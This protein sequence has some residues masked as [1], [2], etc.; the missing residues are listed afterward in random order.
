MTK[1]KVDKNEKY[2]VQ[3]PREKSQLEIKAQ[4]RE[5]EAK[6]REAKVLPKETKISFDSWYH[7]RAARFAKCHLKEIIWADFKS[8]KLNKE[9]KAEVYDKAL[10]RYG[11]KLD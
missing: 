10:E 6:K 9:E 1:K 3:K 7:A 11:I 5:A 8:R 4:I 2:E